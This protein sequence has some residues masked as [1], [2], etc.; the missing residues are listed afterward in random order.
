MPKIPNSTRLYVIADIHGRID[1]L[2]K[3]LKAIRKDANQ[4]QSSRRMLITLGDYIDRGPDAKKVIEKLIR[5]PLRKF[6]KKY[7][8]GNHEDMLLAFLKDP[9]QGI[10]W[11]EN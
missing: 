10:L 2:N 3:L 7:L 11:L 1:L 6:E 4:N 5:L 9:A 8:K